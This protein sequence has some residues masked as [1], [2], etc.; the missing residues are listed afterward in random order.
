MLKI[1]LLSRGRSRKLDEH[2]QKLNKYFEVV[3]CKKQQSNEQSTHER[4][5]GLNL[6]IGTQIHRNPPD[7]VTEKEEDWAKNVVPNKRVRTSLAET[8]VCN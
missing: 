2:L 1:R 4:S 3:N 7:L 5:G 8:R 6:K